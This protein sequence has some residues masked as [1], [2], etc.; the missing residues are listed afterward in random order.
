[1]KDNQ[2]REESTEL[3]GEIASLLI[4]QDQSLLSILKFKRTINQTMISDMSSYVIEL[5]SLDTS[6][7]ILPELLFAGVKDYCEL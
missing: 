2:I 5:F 7:T 6:L 1:M 3:L 4:F